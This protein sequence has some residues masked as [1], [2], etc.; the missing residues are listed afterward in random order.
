MLTRVLDDG[1][2]ALVEL[3]AQLFQREGG[4][5]AARRG[6][7]FFHGLAKIGQPGFEQRLDFGHDHV[8]VLAQGQGAD[9]GASSTI[10]ETSPPKM[11]PRTGPCS[12]RSDG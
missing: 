11:S 2:E 9:G 7:R 6:I 5:E 4:F 12:G 8:R 10:R 3:G 1:L